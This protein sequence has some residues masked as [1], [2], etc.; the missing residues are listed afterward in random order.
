MSTYYCHECARRDGH[1]SPVVPT[2]GLP[3]ASGY[4][5]EKFIKHTIE[6]SGH[7]INSVFNDP[8]WGVYQ[9]YIVAGAASGALEIDDLG[10]KNLVFFAG[11][12]TGLTY[13]NNAFA[14]SSSGV[15]VICS[16]DEAK[17]HA[18]PYAIGLGVQRCATCGRPV[19]DLLVV[20][21]L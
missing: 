4:L 10:R 15:K 20:D 21:L 6:T 11:R 16:E 18:Y 14:M 17:I 19:P 8:R 12:E 9:N 2:S 13:A 3:P 5:L 1:I 7:P